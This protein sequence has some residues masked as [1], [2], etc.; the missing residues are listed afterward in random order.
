M[1]HFLA[2]LLLSS[3]LAAMP[4]CGPPTPAASGID[5][6]DEEEDSAL[7]EAL[8]RRV[9]RSIARARESAVAL[10]YVA[11]DAPSGARRVATGVVLNDRGE[12]LSVRIDPPPAEAPI[13]ARDASGR[14]HRARW[15]AADAE[16]G[17]TLLRVDPKVAE[18]VRPASR[19]PRL[20]SQVLIVGNPYGLGHSVSRGQVAGLD[21]RLEIGPRPLGGLIQID[22]ALHPGDSG[23]SVTNLRGEWLGLVRGGLNTPE[24]GRPTDHDLGFVIPAR[25][26]LWVADQLRD[27][28]RVD[29]AYLGV[30]LDALGKG[31]D[32]PPGAVLDTVVPDTPAARAGLRPGDRVVALDGHAIHLPGDLTDRL[33]RIPAEAEVTLDYFR[34]TS[35]ER[36]ALRTGSRP[37]IS[38]APS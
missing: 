26:A 24:G 4:S 1:L 27:R 22:A 3:L 11:A 33:D 32:N 7:L 29:R 16:T 36:L 9:D 5:P 10:E 34:G 18:P 30:R 12:V 2:F 25:D 20:G 13:V 28:H 6:R 37:P 14:R 31:K 15:V 17:L 21:R 23:A 35:R 19:S 8:E 38:P